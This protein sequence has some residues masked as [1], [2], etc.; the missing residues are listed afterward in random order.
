[1]AKSLFSTRF[2]LTLLIPVLA[3]FFALASGCTSSVGDECT[4]GRDCPVESGSICD[5]TVDNGYCLIQDCVPGSCPADSTC[6]EFDR[7]T[8]YCMA[9][10]ES[11]DEC[12]AGFS[13]RRDYNLQD[14]PVGYCYVPAESSET[15][16]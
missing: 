7:N 13:C 11:D 12:R 4:T 16:Q 6:V 10:C 14:S 1:M 3:L 5:N 2:L 9:L 15:Q 8:R